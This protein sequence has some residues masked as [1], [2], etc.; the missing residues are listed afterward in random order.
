MD[1]LFAWVKMSHVLFFFIVQFAV[2]I[3]WATTLHINVS[4]GKTDIANLESKVE[5]IAPMKKDITYI[6]DNQDGMRAEQQL[7]IKAVARIEAK[8]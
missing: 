4:E 6:K 5:S 1:K 2:G 3:A 7:L 8:L